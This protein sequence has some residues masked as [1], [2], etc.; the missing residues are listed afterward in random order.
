MILKL[1]WTNANKIRYEYVEETEVV[2]TTSTYLKNRTR[3]KA[4]FKERTTSNR[5]N[6]DNVGR[7]VINRSKTTATTVKYGKNLDNMGGHIVNEKLLKLLLALENMEKEN[8]LFC[9]NSGFSLSSGGKYFWFSSLS[10][11]SPL[12][13]LFSSSSSPFNSSCSNSL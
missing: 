11:L 10:P 5:R 13:S 7:H 3:Q 2:E 9:W 8:S 12:L 4:T 1:K 6:L